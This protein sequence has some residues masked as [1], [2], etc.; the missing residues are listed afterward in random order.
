MITKL[1]FYYI[2]SEIYSKRYWLVINRLMKSKL[3]SKP[4]YIFTIDFQHFNQIIVN[5]LST[6][7][8]H[9]K[10]IIVYSILLK[11]PSAPR[12]C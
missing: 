9:F 11:I 3:A 4:R 1:L 12:L 7:Y 2:D 5:L 6:G 8:Q 10:Y